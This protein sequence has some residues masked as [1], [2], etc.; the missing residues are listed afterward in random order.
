MTKEGDTNMEFLSDFLSWAWARHHN[1]LSWY[2]RPM[3]ILPFI[4]FAYKRNWKG[5][6]AT[7]IALLTSM[8]WF[9]A[10][11]TVDPAVEQFLQAEKDYILGDWTLSKVL[12]SLTVPAFFYFLALA[13]WRR[14]WWWGLAVINLAALGKIAW[15]VISGGESG[16]AVL[17][18]AVIGMLVCNV[19]VSLGV[20]FIHNKQAQ[21]VT[22]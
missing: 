22:S 2:I 17:I 12:A 21:K 15:S 18:P 11:A 16:W 4:F 13:F 3:F 6:V 14:S 20:R 7:I 1:V 9:P 5:L 19:A 8:F 10:P